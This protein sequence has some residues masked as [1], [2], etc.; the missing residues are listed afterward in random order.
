MPKSRQAWV[1]LV[2]AHRAK[3]LH[4]SQ[5][6]VGRPHVEQ[7]DMMAFDTEHYEHGR[8]SPLAGKNGHTH[9]AEGHEPEEVLRRLAKQLG[10]QLRE[11]VDQRDIGRLDVFAPPRFL[12]AL[13]EAC[14]D[15]L[16]QRL[17]EHRQDLTNLPT[18]QLH[19]HRAIRWLIGL[20][21]Q[22]K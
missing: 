12:G 3:L 11:W 4:C 13:R 7:Q 16:A 5:T 20:D 14:P 2:D 15:H 21:G 10:A 8:P 9:A 19:Q 18:S 22:R 1:V 6:P 17:A